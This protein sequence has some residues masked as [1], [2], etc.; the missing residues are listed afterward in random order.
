MVQ[1]SPINKKL[2]IKANKFRYQVTKPFKNGF[3]GNFFMNFGYFNF[4]NQQ[5]NSNS[6]NSITEKNHS[7][8]L[9]F[10]FEFIVQMVH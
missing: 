1:F 7:F 2:I 8:E 9:E 4:N 3:V 10:F 6:E 5:G